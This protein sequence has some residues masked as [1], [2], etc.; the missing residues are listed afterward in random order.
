MGEST[1]RIP[2]IGIVAALLCTGELAFFAIPNPEVI[3]S[4]KP[5]EAEN[6]LPFTSFSTYRDPRLTALTLASVQLEPLLILQLEDA[7]GLTMDWASADR[8]AVGYNDGMRAYK[9]LN[10]S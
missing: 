8:V 5:A 10:R 2:K 9:V 3:R 7:I 1:G 4:T 6:Y